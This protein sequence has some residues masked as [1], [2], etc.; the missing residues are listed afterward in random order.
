MTTPPE[1]MGTPSLDD[2]GEGWVTLPV[3]AARLGVSI[4]TLRRRIKAGEVEA[5][6]VQDPSIGGERW[7]IQ[8]EEPAPK[9]EIISIEVLAKLE[10]AWQRVTEATARAEVAEKVLEFERERR[11][12]AEAE[13]ERLRFELLRRPPVGAE[14]TKPRRWWNR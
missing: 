12:R 1:P 3:A 13:T 6:M 9:A 14:P 8:A 2:V 7:M 4:K 10:E 5:R 11:E